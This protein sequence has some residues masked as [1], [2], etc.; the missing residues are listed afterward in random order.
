MVASTIHALRQSLLRSIVRATLAVALALVLATILAVALAHILAIAQVLA[1]L[2]T[3]DCS[4]GRITDIFVV[5]SAPSLF[6]GICFCAGVDN[7]DA[8]PPSCGSLAASS[9]AM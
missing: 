4:C 8:S 5:I 9:S 2:R 6:S 3:H 7:L 1:T